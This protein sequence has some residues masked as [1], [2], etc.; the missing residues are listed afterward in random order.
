MIACEIVGSGGPYSI[1]VH[2]WLR[3][4]SAFDPLKA[5]ACEHSQ[6]WILVDLR[7]YGRSRGE[8]GLYTMDEAADDLIR[9]ADALAIPRAR[10][11]GHSM[12]GLIIQKVAEKAPAR[13]TDLV[14]IAPVPRSGIA[15][16]LR[17]HEL[18]EASC[19]DPEARTRI[20]RHLAAG[21]RFEPPPESWIATSLRETIPG[22]L[23]A[24]LESWGRVER[25]PDPARP[26]PIP[27]TLLV[28]SRDPAITDALIEREFVPAYPALTIHR[29]EDAGHFPIEE[30]PDAL[31]A[32]FSR[33]NEAGGSQ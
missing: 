27:M 18:Y 8:A 30:Q 17:A 13:V 7:G 11:V 28:G 5:I 14:G 22:A 33:S 9:L 26:C 3:A 12:G 6:R 29:I 15:L 20:L 19:H 2:G 25:V 16:D 24:Y 23:R 10:W 1:F 32:Y 21:I 31:C 4:G